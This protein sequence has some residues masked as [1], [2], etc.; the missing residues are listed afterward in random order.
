VW[1]GESQALQGQVQSRDVPRPQAL[2]LKGRRDPPPKKSSIGAK[3]TE[4]F[5]EE[6]L[7]IASLPEI[8]KLF[9][10]KIKSWKEN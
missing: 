7:V 4:V 6:K 9:S 5:T 3:V 8:E 10:H 1:E 2:R